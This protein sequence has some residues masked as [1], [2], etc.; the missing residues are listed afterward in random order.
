M[1][2]NKQTCA[3][4]WAF[5][6]LARLRSASSSFSACWISASVSAMP[7]CCCASCCGLRSQ[8]VRASER[9]GLRAA[10]AWRR[11]RRWAQARWRT[12]AQHGR[13]L[14]RPQTLF[15]DAWLR[16]RP[17]QRTGSPLGVCR[18]AGHRPRSFVVTIDAL[19][20]AEDRRSGHRNTG[21][22]HQPRCSG[23]CRLLTCRMCSQLHIRL[24]KALRRAEPADRDFRQQPWEPL[25]SLRRPAA[26][27]PCRHAWTCSNDQ[28]SPT[29]ARQL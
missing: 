4:C 21:R 6:R 5:S 3:P 24:I 14:D 11:C 22:Q 1:A 7:G 29:S 19:R 23:G 12:G 9:R 10:A 28:I 2:A 26:C 25:A 17:H 13:L 27:K 15:N 18:A 16:R 20:T 8:G